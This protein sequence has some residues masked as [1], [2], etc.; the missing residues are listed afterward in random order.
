MASQ[1]RRYEPPET[2]IDALA[3]RDAVWRTVGGRRPARPMA[4]AP[5]R[6]ARGVC[7][8]GSGGAPV[9]ARQSVGAHTECRG[10]EADR[11]AHAGA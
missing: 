7:G 1:S 10:R 3:L 6:A 5:A 11:V 9:G 2:T 8:G 4:A